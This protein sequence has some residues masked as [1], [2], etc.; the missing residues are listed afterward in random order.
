MGN[1]SSS[2]HHHLSI[3]DKD[4]IDKEKLHNQLFKL[5]NQCPFGDDEII[6]IARCH[7][8]LRKIMQHRRRT[9]DEQA[10]HSMKQDDDADLVTGE[11]LTDWAVFC[12]TLPKPN[13][14]T[15]SNLLS[16]Y[17]CVVRLFVRF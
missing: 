2:T 16:M 12:G 4:K 15:Y 8:Y 9:N 11:F 6:R 13:F 7:C 5:G 10:N 1:H 17:R 3:K 14:H